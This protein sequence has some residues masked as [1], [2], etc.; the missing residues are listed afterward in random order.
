MNYIHGLIHPN[1]FSSDPDSSRATKTIVSILITLIISLIIIFQ[2]NRNFN[3]QLKRSLFF[4]SLICVMSYVYALGRS[5]GPHIRH[6]FGYPLLTLS[7]FFSYYLCIFFEKKKNLMK[8]VSSLSLIFIL[9]INNKIDVDNLINYQIRLKE[10]LFKEDY[11][12][13]NEEEKK[14]VKEAK[15]LLKEYDCIQL[16]SNDAALYYLLRKK[17][18]TKYYYVWSASPKKIQLDL[19]KQMSQTIIIIKGGK[20]NYWDISLE[21]KLFLVDKYINKNFSNKYK[22]YDWYIYKKG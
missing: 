15:P 11:F 6:T 17:S 4:L 2:N 7:I 3:N 8:F 14:F 18:C 22:I 1:L 13:L 20:N 12:F 21:K 10:L 5:D 16:F 19:I 9:L